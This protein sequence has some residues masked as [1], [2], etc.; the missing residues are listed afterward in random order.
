MGCVLGLGKAFF[1]YFA[2][3][4]FLLAMSCSSCAVLALQKKENK[5]RSIL[6][7]SGELPHDE[8]NSSIF[9]YN[10]LFDIESISS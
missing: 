10:K 2:R 3:F 1:A 5:S 7:L 9:F 6:T 4:W 8:P